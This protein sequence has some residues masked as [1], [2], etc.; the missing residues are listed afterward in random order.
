MPL[1]LIQWKHRCTSISVVQGLSSTTTTA[2]A[3]RL[4]LPISSPAAAASSSSPFA[5][6]PQSSHELPPQHPPGGSPR[7][8]YNALVG[9]LFAVSA[10]RGVRWKPEPGRSAATSGR[11]GEAR[12]CSLWSPARPPQGRG[13]GEAAAYDSV[14]G[15]SVWRE[16]TRSREGNGRIRAPVRPDCHAGPWRSDQ[17]HAWESALRRRYADA[18]RR[19][20]AARRRVVSTTPCGASGRICLRST[21]AAVEDS[22]NCHRGRPSSTELEPLRMAGCHRGRPSSTEL[23]PLRMA[24]CHRGRLSWPRLPTA[25]LPSPT[26]PSDLSM[27]HEMYR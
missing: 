21:G 14:G 18:K 9:A 4:C 26:V 17:G 27:K 1:G 2:P 11:Q 16:V 20:G 8:P 5:P 22:G 23:E 24:G 15:C 12:W 7:R 19:H 25:S 10:R 6:N 13:P 3:L